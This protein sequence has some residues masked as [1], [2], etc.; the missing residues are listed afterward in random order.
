MNTKLLARYIF[1]EIMGIAIMGVA[2]FWSAG[3]LIWWQAWACLAIVLA[4]IIGTAIVIL[5]NNPDLLAERLGPRKGA[6]IWDTIIMSLLG[7]IQLARYIIAGLD[8]RNGWSE[9]FPLSLQIIALIICILGYALAVLAT[10]ANAFFSQ[11][12]RLQPERGQ[13]VA[14]GGPYQFVRHPAY[15]GSILYEFATPLLLT[16]W[17]SLILSSV[18][19]LLFI[20]RTALEDHT[21][22]T[23][24]NGYADYAQ[25]T[26]FRLIPGIW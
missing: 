14:T 6:K 2:L 19:V 16:S 24:L 13:T 9:G 1:R 10:A 5:R 11:I 4:W 17:W 21:L 15:T 3:T 22:Q 23:E 20:L 26:R 12:V 18:N 7:V 8:Q 25:K